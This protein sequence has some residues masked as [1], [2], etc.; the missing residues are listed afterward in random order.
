[1][2]GVGDHPKHFASRIEGLCMLL[3]LQKKDDSLQ[4]T[5]ATELGGA[6]LDCERSEARE[7]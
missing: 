2:L 5:L 3:L 6:A 1:M 4:Q 7:E